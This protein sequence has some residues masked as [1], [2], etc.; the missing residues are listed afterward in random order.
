MTKVKFL[1]TN[2]L[3]SRHVPFDGTAGQNVGGSARRASYFAKEAE[4]GEHILKL[5]VG[6]SFLG[7]NYF[8]FFHGEVE[9]R[10]LQHMGYSA[11]AVGNH[12]FDQGGLPNLLAQARKHAPDVALLCANIVHETSK[13]VVFKRFE[14]YSFEGV[15]VAVV[16][17]IGKTAWFVTP[18]EYKEGLEY[19]GAVETAK[20]VVEE[21]QRAHQPALMVCLSHTGLDD[22]DDELAR[23]G[24]FDVIF[25]G[26]QHYYEIMHWRKIKNGRE[27]LL[28]GTLLHPGNWGGTAVAKVVAEFGRDGSLQSLAES[29]QKITAEFEP[30]SAVER[31]LKEYDARMLPIT[32]EVLGSCTSDSMTYEQH[33]GNLRSPLA[34]FVSESLRCSFPSPPQIGVVND[35]AIRNGIP[36]GEVRG[37]GQY[38]LEQASHVR[39]I[40]HLGTHQPSLAV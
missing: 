20:E 11:A 9:M 40:G 13:E 3:H 37:K 6:D 1:V 36:K 31:I 18:A 12:D 28:N 14:V 38:F 2:D 29:T 34:R 7:S 15:K 21:I 35:G 32:S 5:D 33:K 10:L 8:S 30:N 39:I 25:S 22:G 16:G 24:L 26:H 4:G 17:L 27:N 23:T 19:I